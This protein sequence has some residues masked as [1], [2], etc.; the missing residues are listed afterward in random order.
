LRCFRFKSSPLFQRLLSTIGSYESKAQE[1]QH[2]RLSVA[3]ASGG[4]S[5]LRP[6]DTA[7]VHVAVTRSAPTSP[8]HV[9]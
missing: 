2:H 6:L 9:R 5:Q 3:Y 4:Q 7:T 8:L 1:H